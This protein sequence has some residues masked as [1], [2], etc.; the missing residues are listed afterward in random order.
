MDDFQ[1]DLMKRTFAV[2]VCLILIASFAAAQDFQR[3]ELF[4][5]YRLLNQGIDPN[6]KSVGLDRIT[7]HG[8]QT[9]FTVNTHKSLG[10][11]A[12]FSGAYSHPEIS[13][14]QVADMSTYTFMFGPRFVPVRGKVAPF[15]QFLLGAAHTKLSDTLGAGVSDTRNGFAMRA[16]GGLDISLNKFVASR[17]EI[18][19][20]HTRFDLTAISAGNNSQNHFHF[21]TGIVL[22]FGK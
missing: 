11:V 18:G 9:S 1:G 6:L 19:W 13:G 8:W 2:F 7:N 4:G 17:T 22:R 10:L 21:S 14:T 12:D 3:F 16:G 15:G 20:E 5:G